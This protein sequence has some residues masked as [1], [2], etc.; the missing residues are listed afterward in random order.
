MI[1]CPSVEESWK[2]FKRIR[3]VS[4]RLVQIDKLSTELFLYRKPLDTQLSFDQYLKARHHSRY[5][6][7]NMEP[8]QGRKQPK[9]W[10]ETD[11][12][13]MFII[14][15]IL[16]GYHFNGHRAEDTALNVALELPLFN[17]FWP[18]SAVNSSLESTKAESYPAGGEPAPSTADAY[19]DYPL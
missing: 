9:Y 8:S 19:I 4:G 13:L 18:K 17:P 15:I 6:S 5:N 7:S 12:I 10:T 14:T 1:L 3:I 2:Q 16:L 11:R